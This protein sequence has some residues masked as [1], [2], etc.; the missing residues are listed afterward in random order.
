MHNPHLSRQVLQELTNGHIIVWQRY[1]GIS[2]IAQAE[3]LEDFVV[4][5]GRQRISGK[6]HSLQEAKRFLL[7][8]SFPE[9]GDIFYIGIVGS[10]QGF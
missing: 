10:F 1:Q 8:N 2:I 4:L 7:T 5:V 9:K 6:M 3:Q